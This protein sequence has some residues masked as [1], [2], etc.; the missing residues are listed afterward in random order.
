MSLRFFRRLAPAW[1]PARMG[2]FMIMDHLNDELAVRVMSWRLAPGR[3]L[4]S[5]K[6]C[7]PRWRSQPVEKPAETLRLLEV[8]A[9]EEYS[10]DGDRDGNSRTRVR[11]GAT[12]GEACCVSKRRAITWAIARAVGIQVGL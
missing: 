11:I 5:D 3:Y 4:E 10:V 12:T 1:E 2:N 7:I 9:P 8:A 6:T